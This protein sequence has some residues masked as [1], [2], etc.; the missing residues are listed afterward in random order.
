MTKDE[1]EAELAAN[2]AALL[3]SGILL[4]TLSIGILG[5][6]VAR[7]WIELVKQF[8]HF[9]LQHCQPISI[10]RPTF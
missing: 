2:T 7:Y 8:S 10:L 5:Y 1:I 9:T 3:W 6:A 4:G